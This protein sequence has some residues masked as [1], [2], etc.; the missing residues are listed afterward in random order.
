MK[1]NFREY[2]ELQIQKN[3]IKWESKSEIIRASGNNQNRLHLGYHYPRSYV[4]REQ[5]RNCFDKFK[6]FY[7]KF[8]PRKKNYQALRKERLRH[9]TLS[10]NSNAVI[11]TAHQLDK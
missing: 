11:H 4:T 9:L 1:K 8:Y 5:S 7:P 3:N 6:K 10:N 2:L